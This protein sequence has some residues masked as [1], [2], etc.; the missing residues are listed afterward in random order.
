MWINL[1][2]Y[3]V[4]VVVGGVVVVVGG[5]VVVAD[6][7]PKLPYSCRCQKMSKY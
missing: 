3:V 6:G 5:V 4:V 7:S 2:V 1:F